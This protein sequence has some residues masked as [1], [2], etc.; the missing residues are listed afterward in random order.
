[1]INTKNEIVS[2]ERSDW[3]LAKEPARTSGTLCVRKPTELPI[4]RLPPRPADTVTQTPIEEAAAESTKVY[5]PTEFARLLDSSNEAVNAHDFPT[6]RPPALGKLATA[7]RQLTDDEATVLVQAPFLPESESET[8]QVPANVQ[9]LNEPSFRKAKPLLVVGVALGMVVVGFFGFATV[10]RS[11]EKSAEAR[12]AVQVRLNIDVEP[13]QAKL[14]LDNQPLT[15]PLPAE[16][17]ADGALH[18]IRAEAAGYVPR[19]VSVKFETDVLVVLAL[20][21]KQLSD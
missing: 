6:V 11:V 2:N 16:Y 1:M 13:A 4:R 10:A 7:S 14:F 20:G 21:R 12:E 5:H 8:L 15:N 3:P 18:E 9:P 19:I 17:R